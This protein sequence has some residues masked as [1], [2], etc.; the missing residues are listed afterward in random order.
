MARKL[1]AIRTGVNEVGAGV[2]DAIEELLAVDGDRT[3]ST[4]TVIT[5]PHTNKMLPN[6]IHR[7]AGRWNHVILTYSASTTIIVSCTFPSG[8]HRA[9]TVNKPLSAAMFDTSLSSLA[10]S[11]LNSLVESYELIGELN[12][13]LVAVLRD[14]A[15]GNAP[16]ATS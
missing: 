1:Q 5:T 2:G 15:M 14:G 6:K 13:R 16:G 8:T 10:S 3:T 9:S 7:H 4:T 12:D 11:F